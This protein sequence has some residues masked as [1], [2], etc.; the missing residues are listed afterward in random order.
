M[1]RGAD[2][3][4]GRKVGTARLAVSNLFNEGDFVTADVRKVGGHKAAKQG[5][6]S[7]AELKPVLQLKTPTSILFAGVNSSAQPL[8]I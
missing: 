4:W 5:V 8:A 6:C 7:A 3:N 1:L 2:R